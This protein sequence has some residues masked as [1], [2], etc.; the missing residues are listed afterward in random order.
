MGN[1]DTVQNDAAISKSGVTTLKRDIV[2]YTTRLNGIFNDMDQAL[3]GIESY[4]DGNDFTV[5]SDKYNSLK[6]YNRIIIKNIDLHI[7]E[8]NVV[9]N[10]FE[11]MDNQNA[12]AM[13]KAAQAVEDLAHDLQSINN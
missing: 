10:E 4:F 2:T 3:I 7:D 5:L 1:S 9:V 12:E 8:L 6:N 13:Q 11:N